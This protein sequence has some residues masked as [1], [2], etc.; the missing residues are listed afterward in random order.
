M[1][2]RWS[3]STKCFR[4]DMITVNQLRSIMPLHPAAMADYVP[5]LNPAMEEYGITTALREA[6]FLATIAHESH[7]LEW[8]EEKWGPTPA[9]LGYE[10]RA[11]L[12]NTQPGD[13]KKFKGRGP[14]QITGRANYAAVS[15]AL[16]YDFIFNPSALATPL[17]AVQAACWWWKEHGCNALA[18]IGD[19]RAV[20]KRVNG[21]Y[22]G[23]KERQRYY[24]RAML[25]LKPNFSNVQAGSSSTA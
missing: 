24:D 6:A 20:T 2:G 25:V 1:T 23:M 14:I 21:G 3:R 11:D 16:K 9:Q 10:G 19:F 7:E 4:I 12:G 17:Y 5:I 15:K 18:D 22:N 8:L 13:G